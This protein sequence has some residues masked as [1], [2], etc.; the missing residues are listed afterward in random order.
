VMTLTI[1]LLTLA[2]AVLHFVTAIPHGGAAVRLGPLVRALPAAIP[3]RRWSKRASHWDWPR[4]LSPCGEQV[5]LAPRW[6]R[7]PAGA[8]LS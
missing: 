3:R 7:P 4:P 2:N 6:P 8:I 5:V 1:G